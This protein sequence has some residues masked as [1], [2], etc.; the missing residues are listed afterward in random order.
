MRIL[1]AHMRFACFE[2]ADAD[3]EQPLHDL[4]NQEL[5][6]RVKSEVIEDRALFDGVPP[7][8]IQKHF[9]A[10]IE[11]QGVHLPN[12]EPSDPSLH[13]ASSSTHR[14]CIIIDAEALQNLLRFPLRPTSD[15]DMD[16]HIGVKV[17]DVECHANSTD[18]YPPPFDEGWL[19]TSPRSLPEIWFSCP[20]SPPE[21]MR[22]DDNLGRP[23][24]WFG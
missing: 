23:V 7:A 17:L 8:A 13:M 2:D 16:N 22:D 18:G 14:F 11:Q 10:W 24:A 1:S 21:K 12:I 3:S 20:L 4:A 15:Y 9:H 5:W 19:W 6:R